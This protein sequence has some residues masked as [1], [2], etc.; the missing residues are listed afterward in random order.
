MSGTSSGTGDTRT[1]GHWLCCW[2][3]CGCHWLC[4]WLWVQKK[5]KSRTRFFLLYCAH[6][7]GAQ[8]SLQP[9]APAQCW[10]PRTEVVAEGTSLLCCGD[11]S[12][13]SKLCDVLGPCFP[14]GAPVAAAQAGGTFPRA[15][16]WGGDTAGEAPRATFC[17]QPGFWGWKL[18]SWSTTSPPVCHMRT[19][20][21]INPARMHP[22]RITPSGR[23]PIRMDPIRMDPIRMSP[24]SII[25]SG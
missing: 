3:G 19:Y 8:K 20:S 12:L 10:L 14:G 23:V 16:P 9:R 1:P 4:R 7:F 18:K 15:S 11:F 6:A 17:R 13:C 21:R 22:A 2:Q 24:Q 5:K 25:P